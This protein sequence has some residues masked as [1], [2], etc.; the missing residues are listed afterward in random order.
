[1]CAVFRWLV[2]LTPASHD[3]EER[4]LCPAPLCWPLRCALSGLLRTRLLR[5]RSQVPD[6]HQLQIEISQLGQEPT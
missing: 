4:G 5:I 6:G 2:A 1:M 3:G